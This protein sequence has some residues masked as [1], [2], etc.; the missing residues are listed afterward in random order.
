MLA[1][2]NRFFAGESTRKA[3]KEDAK[4]RFFE[5]AFCFF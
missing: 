1:D 2:F 4:K 3:L 5:A